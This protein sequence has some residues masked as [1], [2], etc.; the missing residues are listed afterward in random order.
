MVGYCEISCGGCVYDRKFQNKGHDWKLKHVSIKIH[1]L[2]LCST[3]IEDVQNNEMNLLHKFEFIDLGDLFEDE[4]A[5]RI[6]NEEILK[7][8][9][10]FYFL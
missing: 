8:A 1:V 6:G 5:T 3:V 4:E 10:V 7:Y 9:L 2:L